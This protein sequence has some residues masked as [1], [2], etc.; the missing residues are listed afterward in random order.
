M[1]LLCFFCRKGQKI[2]KLLTVLK[3]RG[4]Q[5]SKEIFSF[6]IEKDGIKMGEKYEE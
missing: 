6:E 4:S 1:E 3:L 5:H 2:K